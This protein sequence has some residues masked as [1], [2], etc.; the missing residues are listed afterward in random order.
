[1]KA[2]VKT[3][4]AEGLWILTGEK[5]ADAYK[6]GTFGGLKPKNEFNMDTGTG[7]GL[8]EVGF[9]VDAFDVTDTSSTGSS[10]N[11]FQG[12]TDALQSGKI[13]ECT[14]PAAGTTCNGG[15]K[16]YTAGVKWVMNPNMMIKANY[17]F[18]DYDTPFY[19]IDIGTKGGSGRSAT[20]LEKISHENL[21]MIRGQ[22]AF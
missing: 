6:K 7:Y 9:R 11:R 4:Y 21:F 17:T 5:Y 2:S 15:A 16:S 20:N 13:D 1:M 3:W 19:P 22:Y 8:W 14:T 18:T 12:T 10:K